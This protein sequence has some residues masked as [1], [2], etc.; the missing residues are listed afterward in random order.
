ML[1]RTKN[2]SKLRM[3]EILLLILISFSPLLSNTMKAGFAILIVLINLKVFTKKV[4]TKKLFFLLFF[5][6]LFILSA[7]YDLRN[8]S[9]ISEYSILNLYF[10]ICFVLGYL[11]S[12]KYSYSE[13]LTLLEKV[14]FIASILSLFGVFV[15][16]FL[17]NMISYLPSY[18]YY[19]TSHKT[20]YVFNVILGHSGNA[21]TRNVGIAWEPGVFQFLVN[22]GLYSYLKTT[23]KINLFK[24]AIY[25]LVV[26]TTESTAGIIIFILLTWKLFLTDKKARILII[27][28]LLA[29]SGLIAEELMYHYRYKLFGSYAFE[30][31]LDPFLNSFN[32]GRNH[33]FGMGNSGYNAQLNIL[34]IGAWD[35]FGQIFIRY[36]YPMFIIIVASLIKIL[37]RDKILFVILFVTFLSQGIWFFPIV[38]PFY[39]IQHEKTNNSINEY[40]FENRHK[41]IKYNEKKRRKIE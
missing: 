33:L 20:A 39:F 37:F 30:S 25:A 18:Q 9:S 38:T 32:E 36:G 6:G 10:P 15:Y 26:I 17:P 24:V 23:K 31:R 8:V 13:F 3:L 19:H 21:V 14:V 27:I 12:E 5:M 41:H 22:I 29:F 35:S 16:T 34:N 7:I 1:L 2:K 28:S 11:V 40:K 4:N